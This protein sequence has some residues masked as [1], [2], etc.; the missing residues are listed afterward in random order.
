MTVPEADLAPSADAA[1]AYLDLLKRCLTR[2]AD[3][4]VF[5]APPLKTEYSAE[6]LATGRSAHQ[7][8]DTMIGWPRLDNLQQCVVTALRDGVPGDLLETGVWRGGSCIFM[9]AVLRA[10]G[11]TDRKVWVADSFQ[12]FPRPDLERYPAD[13]FFATENSRAYFENLDY[14][15]AIS[16]DE[17]KSR[18]RRYGLLDDQVEFLP[19]FFSDTL[20]TAPVG[21]LAVLRLDG[22]FY[23]ST[24]EA[25]DALYPRLSPGGFCIVD[26]YWLPCCKDAV[27]DYRAANGVSEQLQRIDWT[28]AFW[29]KS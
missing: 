16:L 27:T 14:P 22:D 19:G 1:T 5:L 17:V 24:Y 26:D 21:K 11:V 10:Y 2:Y 25:L 23:Q 18:F 13:R 12:G 29:R 7:D 9:R 28:G 20:P 8:A 4:E 3:G 6:D 15:I